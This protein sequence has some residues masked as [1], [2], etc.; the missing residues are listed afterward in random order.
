MHATSCLEFRGKTSTVPDASPVK[1][2]W[3]CSAISRHLTRAEVSSVL[4]T[5]PVKRRKSARLFLLQLQVNVFP[6]MGATIGYF[7]CEIIYILLIFPVFLYHNNKLFCTKTLERRL[8]SSPSL[9]QIF[10]NLMLRKTRKEQTVLV[11]CSQN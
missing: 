8:K 3:F 5:S 4:H 11:I 10:L 2:S 9:K 6:Q 7:I 1:R